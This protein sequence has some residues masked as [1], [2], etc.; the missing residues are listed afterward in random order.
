MLSSEHLRTIATSGKSRQRVTQALRSLIE[1]AESR[2]RGPLRTMKGS[3]TRRAGRRPQNPSKTDTSGRATGPNGQ[4]LKTVTDLQALEGGDVEKCGTSSSP[5]ETES[6]AASNCTNLLVKSASEVDVSAPGKCFG[7]DCEPMAA[8]ETLIGHQG[9]GSAVG[10]S[11][12]LAAFP[13][14]AELKKTEASPSE[15]PIA[16][17]G[18]CPARETAPGLEPMQPLDAVEVPVLAQ[19]ASTTYTVEHEDGLQLQRPLQSPQRTQR[20]PATSVQVLQ[21]SAPAQACR[22]GKTAEP[23]N[24]P[25]PQLSRKSRLSTEEHCCD[26]AHTCSVDDERACAGVERHNSVEGSIHRAIECNEHWR[27]QNRSIGQREDLSLEWQ[28]TATDVSGHEIQQWLLRSLREGPSTNSGSGLS[29][30]VE[31]AQAHNDVRMRIQRLNE[32][33][34][35]AHFDRPAVHGGNWSFQGARLAFVQE[36]AE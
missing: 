34:N 20:S 5:R 32:K 21:P 9:E 31:N 7:G 12:S 24:T 18:P 3:S 33:T 29:I 17:L 35:K 25:S 8:S 1:K 15:R 36:K 19:C 14:V 28:T 11:D 10:S 2:N 26:E 6:S 16:T 22:P 30:R 23:G 13:I 27:G 4:S